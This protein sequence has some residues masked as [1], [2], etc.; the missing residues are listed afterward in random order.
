[1]NIW[2]EAQIRLSLRK[3]MSESRTV[4]M[5]LSE[6]D[7]D[8][9][10]EAVQAF[11]EKTKNMRGSRVL[12]KVNIEQVANKLYEEGDAATFTEDELRAIHTTLTSYAEAN[13]SSGSKVADLKKRIKSAV[14][15]RNESM[16]SGNST[17]D[18]ESGAP[19]ESEEEQ[20]Y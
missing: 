11:I 9:V 18:G 4:Q 10:W 2:E 5:K 13:K 16:G 14:I 12:G 15:G 7:F 17:G 19:E 1:M 6:S 20:V 3:F 8:L